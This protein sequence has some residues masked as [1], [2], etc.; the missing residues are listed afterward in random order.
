MCKR[1]NDPFPKYVFKIDLS[2][3]LG[4]KINKNN[5]SMEI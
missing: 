1:L 2:T 4:W 5:P 3:F